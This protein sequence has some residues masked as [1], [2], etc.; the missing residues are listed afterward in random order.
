MPGAQ[1]DQDKPAGSQKLRLSDDDIRNNNYALQD[2]IARDHVFPTG[3]GTDAG[4]HNRVKFTAPITSPAS[5]AN[6]CYLFPKDADSKVELHW[7]DEDGNELQI[8]S[9]GGYQKILFGA[10]LAADPSA[11]ANKCTLYPKD[12]AGKVELHF[13][14]EDGNVIQLTSAGA[15][16][17]LP[18]GDIPSGT[19]MWFY[20]DSAPTG[21]TLD[22]TPSDELLAIKGG[23]TYTTGG[24]TKGSWTH[25]HTASS[26]G[27]GSSGGPSNNAHN[28]GGGGEPSP[29]VDHIHGISVSVSTTVNDNT[30]M[31]PKARVGIICS[32]D[33]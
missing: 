27:S 19:K 28:V 5:A 29:G 24:T 20:A 11:V 1:F 4:E 15:I 2:A 21:W 30:T 26:S 12:V 25:G 13:I 14:D 33:A 22:G 17:G 31:R 8:T 23:T 32:K 18:S 9:K 3:Y 10:P 16:A 7:L 6:K